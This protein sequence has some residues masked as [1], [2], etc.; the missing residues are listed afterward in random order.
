MGCQDRPVVCETVVAHPQ[1]ATATVLV[2]EF[3]VQA[4]RVGGG[5]PGQAQKADSAV[6]NRPGAQLDD[7]G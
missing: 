7:P 2:G 6:S 1:C 4:S 3:R 5:C